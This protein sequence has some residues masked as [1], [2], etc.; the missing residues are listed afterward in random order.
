MNEQSF[1]VT[2]VYTEHF[3]NGFRNYNIVRLVKAMS[4]EEAVGKFMASPS[5]KEA[6]NGKSLTVDPI[7]FSAVGIESNAR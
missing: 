7:A 4:H 3:R 1:L 5:V 6:T 2:A